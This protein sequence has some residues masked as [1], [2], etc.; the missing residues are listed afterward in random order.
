MASGIHRRW[1][2]SRSCGSSDSGTACV[3]V[4]VAASASYLLLPPS[5]RPFSTTGSARLGASMLT[6]CGC[7]LALR[8]LQ[9]RAAQH[10]GAAE[11]RRIAR[12]LHDGLAQELAF[13]AMLSQQLGPD[14]LDEATLQRLRSAVE[15]A[16]HDSRTAISV[17]VAEDELPLQRLI[18]RTTASFRTRF[19]VEVDVDV[20]DDVVVDAERSRALLRILHEALSNAV[21]HG[22]ADRVQVRFGHDRDGSLLSIADDGGGFDVAAA[23]GSGDGLGLASMHERA[24]LLGGAV[25]VLSDPGRGTVVEARLP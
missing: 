14:G 20:D 1:P 18:A 8:G 9:R 24:A 19:G 6:L 16:L 3:P 13:I 2:P 10:A 25:T 21:H 17:L 4:V 22:G 7:V 5:R 15:R 11:R 23:R 12:D